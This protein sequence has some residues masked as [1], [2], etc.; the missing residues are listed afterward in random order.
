MRG[1]NQGNGV[2]QALWVGVA[3]LAVLQGGCLLVAAGAAGGAA[4]GYAYYKGQVCQDY[5]VSL[6]NS[7]AASRAALGELGLPVVREQR[8]GRSASIESVATTGDHIRLDLDAVN[9]PAPGQ[10]PVTQVCVRVATFGDE[11]LSQRILT[12]LGAHMAPAVQTIAPPLATAQTPNGLVVP[13]AASP[14]SQEP[15]LLSPVPTKAP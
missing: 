11:L 3:A 7:L 15:P 14:Q 8:D 1:V 12:Q 4:L 2:R 6:D 9:A 5:A 10:T 13:A